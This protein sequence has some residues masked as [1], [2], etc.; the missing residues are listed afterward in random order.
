LDHLNPDNTEMIPIA[1]ARY[2]ATNGPS[3]GTVLINPGGP[4]GSGVEFTIRAGGEL[5]SYFDGRYDILGFDPRGVGQS[6][7]ITCFK[8]PGAA[9][10]Y[11]DYGISLGTFGVLGA[12]VSAEQYLAYAKIHADVCAKADQAKYLP[13][14]S[15]ASVV[16]DMDMIREALGEEVLNFLGY[17]YGT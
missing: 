5:S 13:Y 1:V 17:S 12:T 3:L 2:P 15:T 4:G 9:K 14:V 11:R 16:R 6:L 10:F 8:T 7:P